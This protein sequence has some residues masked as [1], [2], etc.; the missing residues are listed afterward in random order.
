M[1]SFL[2]LLSYKKEEGHIFNL[3]E[4]MSVLI[5]KAR[6]CTC[7]YTRRC[8]S[9]RP[10]AYFCAKIRPSA[11]FSASGALFSHLHSK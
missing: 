9:S 7:I 10:S 1:C 5:L 3:I 8:A 6:A 2:L 11:L 4:N